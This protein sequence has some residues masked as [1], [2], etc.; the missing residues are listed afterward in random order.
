MKMFFKIVSYVEGISLLALLFIAMPIKYIAGEPGPVRI[1][2]MTHGVLFLIFFVVV[3]A[4]AHIEKWPLK[5][6]IFA[7]ISSSIPFGMFALEKKLKD[8]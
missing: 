8:N 2:G 7:L 4:V 3:F 1:V 5:L 6:F